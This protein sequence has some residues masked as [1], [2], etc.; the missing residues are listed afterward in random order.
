MSSVTPKKKISQRGNHDEITKKLM[1]KLQDTINQN[2]KMHSRNI[3][4]P[5]MK[6]FEK[7][8]K[9]LNELRED[10]KNTKV[11][12]RRLFKKERYMK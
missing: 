10:L 3:K 5:Q 8:H 1:E 9:L 12:Q 2:Y 6:K 4:T 7:T 11:K